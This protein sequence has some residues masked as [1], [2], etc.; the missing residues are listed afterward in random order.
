MRVDVLYLKEHH[1]IINEFSL[2]QSMHIIMYV[3][4]L[5]PNDGSRNAWPCEC[6]C[7]SSCH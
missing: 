3:M 1:R 7:P 5:K 4:Y 6:L 2:S